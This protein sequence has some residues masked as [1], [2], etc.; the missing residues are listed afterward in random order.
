MLRSIVGVLAGY[1]AMAVFVFAAFTI[2][3]LA[4]GADGAFRA[5]LYEVSVLWIIVSFVLSVI[6]AIVGGFVCAAIARNL[7]APHVLAGI[8]LVLGLL[9]SIPVIT[10]SYEGMPE[11]RDGATGNFEAMQYARQP[12]WIALLNPII[13]AGGIVFGAR[14][15]KRPD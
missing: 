9:F 11:V 13:G 14:M 10:G 15:R 12:V 5:G 7:T 8:V 4:M 6:V 3:Y 1:L 2:A